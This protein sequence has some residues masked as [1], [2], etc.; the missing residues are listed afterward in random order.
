MM[1][2][3]DFTTKSFMEKITLGS[4]TKTK[5]KMSM[6]NAYSFSFPKFSQ[7]SIFDFPVKQTQVVKNLLFHILSDFIQVLNL[8]IHLAF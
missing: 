6:S 4:S 2:L 5:V 3:Y 7:L 8:F 1:Y